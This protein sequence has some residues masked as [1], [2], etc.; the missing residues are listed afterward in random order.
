MEEVSRIY[1]I[2]ARDLLESYAVYDYKMIF[3][4]CIRVIITFILNQITL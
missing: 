4:V 3:I 1:V 2:Y